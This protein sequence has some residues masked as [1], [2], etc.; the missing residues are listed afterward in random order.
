[1]NRFEDLLI[2]L[3]IP[4]GWNIVKNNFIDITKVDFSDLNNEQKFIFQSIY[5]DDNIFHAVFT[6]NGAN[7]S[8]I[9]YVF[10]HYESEK[11]YELNFLGVKNIKKRKIVFEE[12]FFFEKID[13]LLHFLNLKFLDV[14]LNFD[15]IFKEY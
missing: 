1:M 9:I 7:F 12:A 5:I 11:P 14:Y 3:K 8:A 15:E 13:D 10:S 6:P 2:P 4:S